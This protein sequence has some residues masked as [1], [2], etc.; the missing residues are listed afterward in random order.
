MTPHDSKRLIGLDDY[1][2]SLD[3]EQQARIDKRYRE[4]REELRGWESPKCLLVVDSVPDGGKDAVRAMFD[5][6]GTESIRAVDSMIALH[7]DPVGARCSTKWRGKT[8][9][10]RRGKT[11]SI[12]SRS[13]PN[14]ADS[15]LEANLKAMAELMHPN[16]QEDIKH[17]VALASNH[18]KYWE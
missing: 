1:L 18:H 12:T 2:A 3:P 14:I 11:W 7:P 9:V 17:Q 5:L 13:L 10:Y 4:L 16:V 8:F 15:L 6:Y